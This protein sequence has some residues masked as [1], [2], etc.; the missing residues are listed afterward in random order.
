MVLSKTTRKSAALLAVFFFCFALQVQAMPLPVQGGSAASGFSALPDED[1]G[2]VEIEDDE[3]KP[4]GKKS[5]LTPILIGLAAAGVVAALLFLVVLKSSWD[6][7]GSWDLT[8]TQSG[9][10]YKEYLTLVCTGSK[11]EGT[12]RFTLAHSGTGTYSVQGKDD[13]AVTIPIPPGPT[14]S[15]QGRFDGKDQISGRAT[16]DYGYEG[17]F[18]GSRSAAGSLSQPVSAK[19][20]QG[21][22]A[23]K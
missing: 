1:Q 6:L 3:Y 13:F 16:N 17:T 22:T 4:A 8:I 14:I 18:I 21:I 20:D 2:L 19:R 11:K 5:S 7:S 10:G 23:K 12:A 15:L 9:S